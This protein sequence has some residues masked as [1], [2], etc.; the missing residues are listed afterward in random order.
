MPGGRGIS[1]AYFHVLKSFFFFSRRGVQCPPPLYNIVVFAGFRACCPRRSSKTPVTIF[2][3]MYLSIPHAPRSAKFRPR[4]RKSCPISSTRV[5]GT[6][7]HTGKSNTFRFTSVLVVITSIK[8]HAS[9]A[10]VA[11]AT[12]LFQPGSLFFSF[13]FLLFSRK[14]SPGTIVSAGPV[15]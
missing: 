10:A 1:T 9:A 2:A 7:L 11:A 14:K 6:R 3:E 12:A 4:R 5:G 15:S 13:F 8:L